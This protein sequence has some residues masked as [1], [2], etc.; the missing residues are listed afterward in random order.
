MKSTP[1]PFMV[2]ADDDGRAV[3]LSV[4]GRASSAATSCAHV[5]AVDLD[6]VPPEGAPLVRIGLEDDALLGEARHE[7]AVAVDEGDEVA[8]L[9]CCGRPSRPP[10]TEPSPV[11]PSP[12]SADDAVVVRRGGGR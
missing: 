6:H 7:L 12:R 8:Q 10:S 11:S 3:W 4:P 1:L 2:S 5:V 9:G